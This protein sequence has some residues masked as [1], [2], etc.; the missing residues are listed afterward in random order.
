MESGMNKHISTQG[1]L[2]LLMG[3]GGFKTFVEF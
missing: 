1:K 3:Q 2:E